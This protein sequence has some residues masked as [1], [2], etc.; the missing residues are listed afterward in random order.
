MLKLSAGFSQQLCKYLLLNPCFRMLGFSYGLATVHEFGTWNFGN[1]SG[2][3]PAIA[4][5]ECSGTETDIGE[6]A[7]IKAGPPG[8][9]CLADAAAGVMCSNPPEGRCI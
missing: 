6:C 2:T 5:V 3:V 9:Y 4:S 7:H 1:F 8:G